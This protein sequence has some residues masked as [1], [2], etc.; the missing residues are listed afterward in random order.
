MYPN[1]YGATHTDQGFRVQCYQIY[2]FHHKEKNSA[3]TSYN[4]VLS[5]FKNDEDSNS[6]SN[7]IST[8]ILICI[9]ICFLRKYMVKKSKWKW[10]GRLCCQIHISVV[11][12]KYELKICYML[13]FGYDKDKSLDSELFPVSFKIE[14]A[15]STNFYSIFTL[16]SA[17]YRSIQSHWKRY[18][19]KIA[20][21]LFINEIYIAAHLTKS[22]SGWHATQT[23]PHIKI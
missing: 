14:V 13:Y 22:S 10:F 7:R 8:N 5:H 9:N 2:T 3:I 11:K 21:H 15:I 16:L 17:F 19:G 6:N 18:F 4:N 23:K 1:L 12:H 20:G